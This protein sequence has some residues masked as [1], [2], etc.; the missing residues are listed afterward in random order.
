LPHSRS[1]LVYSLVLG[2]IPSCS[3]IARADTLKEIDSP[4]PAVKRR[5]LIEKVEQPKATVL[6]L[7]DGYGVVKIGTI[8]GSASPG[9]VW[10][11]GGSPP[12][13]DPCAPL[14]YHA[15]LGIEDRV[16]NAMTGFIKANM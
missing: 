3:S 6:M 8:F 9:F 1:P 15:F 11:E 5:M 10:I 16:L 14:A 12:K 2:F 4:R 13:S 7:P